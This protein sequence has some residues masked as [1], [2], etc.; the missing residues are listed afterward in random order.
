MDKRGEEAEG[1]D[2]RS[3]SLA[4]WEC[5]S[6]SS[7]RSLHQMRP[8]A[9]S[10]ASSRKPS[11]THKGSVPNAPAPTR[12]AGG[13]AP[14]TVRQSKCSDVHPSDGSRVSIGK[15]LPALHTAA[16]PPVEE[17][18]HAH[19][20]RG[21]SRRASRCQ[22]KGLRTKGIRRIGVANFSSA[23]FCSTSFYSA[24]SCSPVLCS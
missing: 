14:P 13:A 23:V 21:L 9:L 20:V 19:T 8:A 17:A 15:R 4:S 2:F 18:Q 3:S 11:A 12:H 10:R 7:F 24:V 1:I 5:Q 16:P 22:E 6:P